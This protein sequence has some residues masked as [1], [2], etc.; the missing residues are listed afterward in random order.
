MPDRSTRREWIGRTLWTAAG[1]TVGTGAA[2]GATSGPAL[3]DTPVPSDSETLG[4]VLEVERLIVLGYRQVLAA[5]TLGPAD[6]AAL[7]PFLAH[8]LEHVATLAAH[9]KALGAPADTAPLD[10]KSGDALLG[11]YHVSGSVTDVQTRKDSFRLLVDLESLA[12]GAYFTA[13]KTLGTDELVTMS[14]QAMACEAQ[15][16]T[17]LSGLRNPG[18]YVKSVPWPF[19]TGS[20]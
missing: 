6:N 19:V 18:I 1:A 11:K 12:E 9:L 13:L 14:A 16:W 20:S 8:E 17:V 10:V 7:Q 5:G 2:L 3:A 15:H 4:K